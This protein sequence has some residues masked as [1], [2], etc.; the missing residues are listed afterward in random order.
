MHWRMLERISVL[1]VSTKYILFECVDETQRDHDHLKQPLRKTKT[2]KWW[3][4]PTQNV[5]EVVTGYL[6]SDHLL[7]I[8]ELTVNNKLVYEL[9]SE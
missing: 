6:V 5:R 2:N 1:I 7:C 8:V 3:V 4:V 9:M